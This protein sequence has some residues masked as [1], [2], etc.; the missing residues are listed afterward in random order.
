M[1]ATGKLKARQEREEEPDREGER[2]RER[3]REGER[4]RES[5]REGERGWLYGSGCRVSRV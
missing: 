3:E 5:D 1:G 4:G 2:R